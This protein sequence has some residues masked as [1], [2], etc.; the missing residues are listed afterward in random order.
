M[1]FIGA[2]NISTPDVPGTYTY[3]PNGVM[4]IK[5][6]ATHSS[7]T[8]QEL[9]IGTPYIISQLGGSTNQAKIIKGSSTLPLQIVFVDTLPSILDT[10]KAYICTKEGYRSAFYLSPLHLNAT[11]EYRIAASASI[12]SVNMLNA[13]FPVGDIKSLMFRV[14]NN[15]YLKPCDGTTGLLRVQEYPEYTALVK[16]A[17]ILSIVGGDGIST[18]G[19]PDLTNVSP[20][21]IG[22][23]NVG[24]LINGIPNTKDLL[25][26]DKFEKSTM[27]KVGFNTHGRNVN[28]GKSNDSNG[29]RNDAAG[30]TGPRPNQGMQ[31]YNFNIPALAP[32]FDSPAIA[33]TSKVQIA[34]DIIAPPFAPM[35]PHI[36]VR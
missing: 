27:A 3:P 17:G 1:K 18:I 4:S 2:I 36:M 12:V 19:V 10:T 34:D 13:M 29:K 32:N 5:L 22:L 31:N 30:H 7:P 25:V 28:N 11:F 14:T 20:M 8:G 33:D 9:A 15:I 23:R 24:D 16:K 35:Y 6:D 26:G 21:W